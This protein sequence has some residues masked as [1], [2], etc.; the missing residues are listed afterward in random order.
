M[1]AQRAECHIVNTVF[2]HIVAEMVVTAKNS[3]NLIA[4]LK[5]FDRL[6]A[7]EYYVVIQIFI[8]PEH[9]KLVAK[10]KHRLL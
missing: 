5:Y 2:K 8:L 10:N 4:L 9:K 3:F 6:I 1:Q 7:V